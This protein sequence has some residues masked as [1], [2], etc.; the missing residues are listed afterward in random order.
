MACSRGRTAAA[1]GQARDPTEVGNTLFFSKIAGRIMPDKYI[2]REEGL[3][4]HFNST[5]N[6]GQFGKR[7]K[8]NYM[9]SQLKPVILV[10]YMLYFPEYGYKSGRCQVLAI[11]CIRLFQ[12]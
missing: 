9:L 5:I 2:D 1:H 3:A 7:K 8:K 11:H 10:E 6:L 12:L 4:I